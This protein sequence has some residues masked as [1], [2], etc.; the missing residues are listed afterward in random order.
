M[1]SCSLP[2]SSVPLQILTEGRTSSDHPA[3]PPSPLS[4]DSSAS[5]RLSQFFYRPPAALPGPS[6]SSRGPQTFGNQLRRGER[7]ISSALF[8]LLAF[9]QD[10]SVKSQPAS[11]PPVRA[12]PA[13]PTARHPARRTDPCSAE[14]AHVE[15]AELHSLTLASL[16]RS[17]GS[18][19]PPTPEKDRCTN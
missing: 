10:K 19:F 13:H 18:R 1:S 16:I 12:T 4:H 11:T 8:F 9:Y 17:R 6:S 5:M 2:V 3:S 15:L 14:V 7:G